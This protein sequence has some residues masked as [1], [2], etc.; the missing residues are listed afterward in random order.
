MNLDEID[1]IHD[2]EPDRAAVGLRALDAAALASDRLPLLAFLTI[3]V[4]GEK[5]GQWDEAAERLAQLCG[6][7]ADAPLAVLAHAAAAS[8]LAGRRDNPALA[9][10]G[11]A[12]GAA[13][14]NTLVQLNALGWRPPTD[15]AELAA[16]LQ[17]LAADSQQFDPGGPLGQRL[18]IALNNTTSRLLDLAAT[19]LDPQTRSALLVGAAAALRFWQANGTW[20]HLERALYLRALVHNRIDEP[21]AARD[22][23]LRALEVIAANGEEEVDRTFLQLQLAAALLRLGDD[24]GRRH[25][26]EARASAAGWD[27]ASLKSWF[28]SEHD[29]LFGGMEKQQ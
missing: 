17:P 19:P 16:R 15:A 2:D 10:L 5:L 9:G 6:T 3:H 1:R 27:D 7:R 12:G 25:L 28:A 26:A 21:A 4:L 24:E 29:R 13:Q 8:H 14:A 18:A 23:C 11:A 22:D 20:V